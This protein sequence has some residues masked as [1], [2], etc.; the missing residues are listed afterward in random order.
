MLTSHTNLETVSISSCMKQLATILSVLIYAMVNSL[1]HAQSLDTTLIFHSDILSE[2]RVIKIGLPSAY[3]ETNDSF[4]SIYVLD[5]EYKYDV[6]RSSQQYLEI[7]TRIPNSVL[8]GIANLSRDSR[9]RDLLPSTFDGIDSLFREFIDKEL[10]PFI[11][12]TYRANSKRTISGHSHGG[13]FALSTLLTEPRLF[14]S[15][16]AIDA[17]FQ[18]VNSMLPDSLTS[19]HVG[20]SLYFTSSDGFYGFN[21]EISSDMITNN[22]IFNNYLVKQDVHGFKYY[23]EHIPDDHGNSFITGFHRGLRWVNNWPISIETLE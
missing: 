11:E 22:V 2:D 12:S 19:I 1:C 20:K 15:Y 23:R 8:I 7:S 21:E 9:N 10:I 16:I 14:D 17:S 6:C 4:S 5:A 3:F 18:I 13:V